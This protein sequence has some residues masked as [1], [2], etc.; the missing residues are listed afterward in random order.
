MKNTNSLIISGYLI[1]NYSEDDSDKENNKQMDAILESSEDKVK[2]L[3]Q[4]TNGLTLV[5]FPPRTNSLLL[6]VPLR[7]VCFLLLNSLFLVVVS[8]SSHISDRVHCHLV[9]VVLF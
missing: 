9:Y 7:F 2:T 1:E 3:A 6:S 5:P 4:Q 8:C